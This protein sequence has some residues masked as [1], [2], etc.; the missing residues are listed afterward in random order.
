MSP[1]DTLDRR[2]LSRSYWHRGPS[3]NNHVP[4]TTPRHGAAAAAA[5]AVAAAAA[6]QPTR[7]DALPGSGFVLSFI[8]PSI[9]QTTCLI[10]AYPRNER[11]SCKR[12]RK[13]SRICKSIRNCVKYQT[14]E[15]RYYRSRA[16]ECQRVCARAYV[17]A[18]CVRAC[19]RRACICTSRVVRDRQSRE[20]RARAERRLRCADVPVHRL[21]R[22]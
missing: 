22:V 13:V 8:H 18:A 17:R 21:I 6:P 12:P 11:K 20:S 14:V 1:R 5:V 2:F 4:A 9:R 3:E 16:V 10:L 7:R 15:S 19:M